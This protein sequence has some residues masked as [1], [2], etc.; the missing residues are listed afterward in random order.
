MK[1]F[2]PTASF[3]CVGC[4]HVYRSLPGAKDFIPCPRCGS[5]CAKWLDYG[6]F[7]LER[8]RSRA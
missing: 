8:L 5:L 2:D 3:Q 4:A 1:R 6:R 7:V